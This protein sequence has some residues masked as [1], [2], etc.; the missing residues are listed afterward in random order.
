[1]SKVSVSIDMEDLV[2]TIYTNNKHKELLEKLGKIMEKEDM[3][4]A[5]FGY[6]EIFDIVELMIEFLDIEEL[7]QLLNKTQEM[8]Y[9][10]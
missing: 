8:L 9:D 7:K 2:E 5:F 4:D 10:G 1:M 3:V 6:G